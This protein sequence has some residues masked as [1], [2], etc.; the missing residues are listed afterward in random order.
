M[1]QSNFK[2]VKFIENANYLQTFF[3]SKNKTNELLRC[4]LFSLGLS[5][6]NNNVHFFSLNV[7]MNCQ[8]ELSLARALSI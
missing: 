4:A 1:H 8:S 6:L 3:F 7:G 2:S 5:L